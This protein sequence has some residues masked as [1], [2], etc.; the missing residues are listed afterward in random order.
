MPVFYRPRFYV[1]LSFILLVSFSASAQRSTALPRSTPEAEGVSSRELLRFVNAADKSEVE[2]HSLM[3]LRNGKVIAEGWWSPY[4]PDLKHTMYSVSKSW[5]STAIGFAVAEKLITVEDPVIKFFPDQLPDTVSDALKELKI[6]HLLTMSVGHDPDPTFSIVASADNWVKAFLARKIDNRPGSRFLYNTTATY[7]LSAIIQKVTG[8]QL[9]EYLK[10]RLFDPLDIRDVDSEIDPLGINTGGWGLRIQ[11]EAMAKFGQLYLNDGQWN[12]RQILPKEWIAEATKAQIM[13]APAATQAV[14]DSS[15][16]LQGYGYQFWRSRHN[17]FR[18]DGAYGQFIIVIPEKEVVIVFTAETPDM[19]KEIN[20]AWEYI[21]PAIMDKPLVE[22]P[23]GVGLLKK[24]LESL[25]LPI[26]SG[27]AFSNTVNPLGKEI[28]LQPNDFNLEAIGFVKKADH[29]EVSFMTPSDRFVIPFANGNWAFS[30]TKKHGPYLV[31][32]ARA[33]FAGLPPFKVAGAYFW[34]DD[35]TLQL[36]LRYIE[37]P[38]TETFD[39]KFSEKTAEIVVTHSLN[40]G[41]PVE[42]KGSIF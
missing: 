2:F 41:S 37:S 33:K 3:I 8:Q 10:P 15:D 22:D 38:H 40:P 5:T 35:S 39:I 17:A 13:Q 31:S 11:T 27:K 23:E 25:T 20:L 32:G 34:K 26:P 36:T 30:E 24:K 6:K 1:A 18:A 19:Q 28:S 9:V 42:I 12:G 29:L 14:R 7:M 16:W 21:L 4:R